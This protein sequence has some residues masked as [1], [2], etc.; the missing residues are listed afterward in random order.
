MT[1]TRTAG[2]TAAVTVDVDLT[3]Q[4][5]VHTG[6]TFVKSTSGLPATILPAAT[7]A[8][9]TGFIA[10]VGNAQVVLSWDPPASGSGVTRHEFRYKTSGDYQA[11][12]QIANSAVGGANQAEFTVPALTNEVAHTFELRAVSAGGNSA[13]AQAG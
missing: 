2:T 7:P 10:T 5:T 6:Y 4:P 3:T 1:V 12:R 8:A 9:P 13:A 11:W